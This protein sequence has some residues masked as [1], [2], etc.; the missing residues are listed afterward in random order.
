MKLIKLL[1]IIFTVMFLSLPVFA[2]VMPYYSSSISR[3]I[4]GFIQVPESFNIY[5]SPSQGSDLLETISWNKT[6]VKL[7]DGFLEPGETFSVLLYDQRIAFCSV[8]D[9]ENGWYK[10]IYDKKNNLSGWFKPAI[11]QDFWNL[12]DFYSSFGRKYGLYY[13][14][15]IPSSKKNIYS[16]ASDEAQKIDGFDFAKF[17]KLVIIRG[18]WALVSVVDLDN[19]P[20]TGFVKWRTAEGDLYLFP[21]FDK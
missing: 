17:I 18:N 19:Q 9:E 6:E 14:K 21:K 20:K 11:P 1:F 7:K 13:F 3:D 5:S 16:A 12:R 10:V 4:I 2:D 15:D 8:L